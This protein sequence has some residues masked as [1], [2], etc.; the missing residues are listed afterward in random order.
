MRLLFTADLHGG[1]AGFGGSGSSVNGAYPGRW[2]FV[3]IDVD[4]RDVTF[5]GGT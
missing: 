2:K 3:G 1:D 4:S 5:V